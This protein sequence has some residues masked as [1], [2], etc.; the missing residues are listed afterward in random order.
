M[1]CEYRILEVNPV[2]EGPRIWID[3]P[4]T[5]TYLREMGYEVG[6]WVQLAQ[7]RM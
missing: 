4:N 7:G 2:L 5:E 6:E 1:R 3:R